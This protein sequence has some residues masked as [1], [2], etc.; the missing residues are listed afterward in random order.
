MNYKLLIFILLISVAKASSQELRSVQE[1]VFQV[2]EKLRYKLRYGF[3]TAAE[4]N[5]RVESTDTKFEGKPVFHLVAEGKTAGS[6]DVFYKVRNRYDS[7]IDQKDLSPY[8]YTESIREANYRR[9]DRARFYQDEKKIVS[10][11][12]TFK[13]DGQTFDVLSAYYFARSLDITKLSVGSKFSMDYFLDD[14]VTKLTIQYVGKERVKTALGYFNCL[15]FSP[16]IQPGR[17]FRKDSKLYLWITD[18]GNRIPVK[19]QVEILVGSVTLEL[20]SAS[21]LKYPLTALKK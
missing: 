6:F 10:N 14:G 18:D 7:Y 21:G 16:S 1:P 8:L 3:I 9:S 20:A 12:G 19:A 17:I 2:G 11:K 4:A 13:G 5:I 15:K